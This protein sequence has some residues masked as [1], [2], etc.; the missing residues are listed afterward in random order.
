MLLSHPEWSVE[1]ALKRFL[2]VAS[3][4]ACIVAPY[5]LCNY[6]LYGHFVPVSGAIKST[7]PA[8]TGN[9]KNLGR[10]GQ[11]VSV[12]GVLSVLLSFDRG[13]N[14]LQKTLLRTL[15][16]GVLL[17]AS[18]VVLYTKHYTFWPWYYVLGVVNLAFLS[19]AILQRIASISYR[20]VGHKFTVR[21][22]NLILALLVVAGVMRAWLKAYN[23]ESIGP[24]PIPQINE[25]RWPDQ[26]AAWIR[27]KIPSGSTVF[28][29]DWPGAIAYYSDARILPMDGLMNDF[30]YNDDLVAQGINQYLCTKDVRFFLGPEEPHENGLREFG[31]LAPLYREPVGAI[32]LLDQNLVVRVKDVVSCAQEA[33]PIA[34]WRIEPCKDLSSSSSGTGV[35]ATSPQLQLDQD[36]QRALPLSGPDSRPTIVDIIS[37]EPALRWH[38]LQEC[39]STV[40]PRQRWPANA[41]AIALCRRSELPKWIG[42][43]DSRS[44]TLDTSRFPS[45]VVP[46]AGTMV[47]S[48]ELAPYRWPN[49]TRLVPGIII[50]LQWD[51]V[52]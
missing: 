13:L 32:K 50:R 40:N 4:F 15:G 5:L 20:F 42:T 19:G 6:S 46:L 37:V 26:V 52:V 7:F 21:I 34:I 1:K 23:P 25:C 44:Y 18:Y 12:F 33:P 38:A 48:Q 47:G 30:K 45:A 2:L 35:A 49:L 14:G 31:V 16:T 29:Y 27:E 8:V 22:T 17:H 28:V 24:L 3:L 41:A 43:L 10:F 51:S 11:G 9:I 36:T 39:A